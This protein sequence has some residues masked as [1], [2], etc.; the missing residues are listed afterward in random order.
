VLAGAFRACA[1]GACALLLVAGAVVLWPAVEPG[2]LLEAGRAGEP[3]RA[4]GARGTRPDLGALEPLRLRPDEPF[5]ARFSG[6]WRVA[7]SGPR[8]LAVAS[9]GAVQVKVDDLEVL[10]RKALAR[11]ARDQAPLSLDAGPHRFVAT[12]QGPATQLRFT[13]I[14]EGGQ[15]REFG[16]YELVTRPPSRAVE[17]WLRAGALAGRLLPFFAGAAFALAVP[18]FFRLRRRDPEAARRLLRLAPSALAVVVFLYGSALRLEALFDRC[19]REERPA[20]AERLLPVVRAI[21]PRSVGWTIPRGPY[22]GDPLAYLRHARQMRHFYESRFREPMF[23]AAA[24]VGLVVMGGRDIGISVAS[25]VFSAFAILAIYALGATAVSPLAGLV[26]AAGFALDQWVVHW[27]VEGVRDDAFAFFIVLTT[28]LAVRFHDT[29]ARREAVGLGVAA[30]GTTLTRITSFSVIVPLFL[31]LAFLPRERPSRDRI[32]GALLA[33]VVF[34]ALTAPFMVSCWIVQ[35]DPFH[36]I[37]AVT[38]AYYGDGAVPKDASVLNMFRASFRPFRLLDTAFLGYTSYPFAAKWHF[39]GFWPPLGSILSILALLG[40][41]LLLLHGR[42]RILW[43]VWAT[44]LFPFVFTW[45]VHGGDAWRLTLFAYPFYLIA[46][47]AALHG[48]LRLAGSRESRREAKSWLDRQ[49]LV[50]WAAALTGITAALLFAFFG[51]YYLVAG[52]AV[53]SGRSAIVAA[54]PRD[55]L[56]FVRGFG[57]P[58]ATPN[59]YVRNSRGEPAEM[60]IPL[61]PG[62]DHRLALRINPLDPERKVGETVR[63]ALNGAS[64]GTFALAFDPDR[65]GAYELAVPAALVK[66]RDNRLQLQGGFVFWY[67]TIEPS[68]VPELR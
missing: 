5:T 15:T 16:T 48:I 58:L 30:A 6:I 27:S 28:L 12:V 38:P 45:R 47:G 60:R 9:D 11:H 51:L 66:A 46:S 68:P 57:R 50:P 8:R 42:G 55:H 10:T 44:T 29:G 1:A 63:V 13:L 17:L 23:V 25:M 32:R 39:E 52:E 49:P 19:W 3:S 62:T 40:A 61:R 22:T 4:V 41:P 26:A 65:F 36:S 24:K 18:V 33:G 54:S 37:N 34:L 7:R 53:R 21:H 56:F 31:I 59:M 64:L 20:W 2:L 43:L 14:E 35:G 67:L